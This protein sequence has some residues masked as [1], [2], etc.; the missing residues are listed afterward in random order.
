MYMEK[1]SNYI[2]I[3][4]RIQDVKLQKKYIPPNSF[5]NRLK[6]KKILLKKE[7]NGCFLTKILYT[8][9]QQFSP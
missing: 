6:R 7:K 4:G 1:L 8:S 9:C 2:L 3:L 5:K